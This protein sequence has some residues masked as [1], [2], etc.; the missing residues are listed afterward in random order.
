MGELEYLSPL[1]MTG[2]CPPPVVPSLLAP[3]WVCVALG[4][5]DEPHEA[6]P[7]LIIFRVKRGKTFSEM[8]FSNQKTL[9]RGREVPVHIVS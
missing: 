8:I 7:Q 3:I 5:I 6:V 4:D 9:S 1:V 2:F